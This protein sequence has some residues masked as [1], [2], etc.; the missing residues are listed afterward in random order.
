[1]NNPHPDHLL[2]CLIFMGRYHGNTVTADALLAGLPTADGRLTPELFSRAATRCGLS[3]KVVHRPLEGI[4]ESLL[5]AVLMLN[6]DQACLLMGWDDSGEALVVYP[7]DSHEP[8]A[9]SRDSLQQLYS[10]VVLLARPK[11][12]F[13][14]RAP[15]LKSDKNSHWFWSVFFENK[16]LY[17]DVLVAAFLVNLFALALPIFTMNVYDRVV[18]NHAVET[19]WMLAIGVILVLMGDLSLKTMRGYF[20][21]LAGRRVDTKLTATIMERVLGMR[22]EYKPQSVGSFASNLRSFEVIREFM[23]SAALATLIDLPFVLVF[24]AVLVWISPWLVLP[25]L[26][27]MLIIVAYAF[28]T[29]AKMEELTETT[30]RTSA[31]RNA[32]LV[33]GLGGLETVKALAAEGGIQRRWERSAEFL[34]RV[35]SQLKLLSSSNGNV[36]AWTQQVVSVSIIVTGVYLITAG[37]LTM[38][39]LIAASM[40]TGR[41]MAPLGQVAALTTQL[42]HVKTSFESLDEI[43]GQEIERPDGSHFLSRKSFNGQIEFRNV[44]FSYPGSEVKALNNVSFTIKPG[45]SVAVLGRIGSG[46]TTLHKLVMGLYKPTEGAV[47]VDG[48]D[49]RQLDPAELR[50]HIGYVPQDVTLFYGSLRENIVMGNPQATDDDVLNAAEF[51]NLNDFVNAHPE[52]FD[53]QVGERGEFLSGGQ[54]KSVSLARSLVNNPPMLL[55]DEPTGSMDQSTESWVRAKLQDYATDRTLLMVTHRTTLLPLVDRILVVDKGQIVADGQRDK[56]VEA[57]RQGRIGKVV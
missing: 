27:G 10:G 43:M 3:S 29:Q 33:E 22:L 41:A 6:D 25:L 52:G 46:K 37:E 56:V 45:E 36:A 7:H 40:L 38:G 21:D 55:L 51:A 50:R 39:G 23:S 13:D 26:V 57:L 19:L 54:R 11:F 14:D 8:V 15:S 31:M 32:V 1:M 20:I 28:S 44:S 12:K 35:G 30:Y 42:H 5:P 4:S 49:T 9:V 48:I 47:L 2:E 18:P 34:A 53:M 16:R 24:L 17:R